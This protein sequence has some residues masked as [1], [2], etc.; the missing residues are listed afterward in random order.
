MPTAKRNCTFLT[1]APLVQMDRHAAIAVEYTHPDS[2]PYLRHS[3]SKR[4]A[5]PADHPPIPWGA[6]TTWAGLALPLVNSHS[7]TASTAAS[8]LPWERMASA[9]QRATLLRSSADRGA[10]DL[11]NFCCLSSQWPASSLFSASARGRIDGATGV[12]LKKHLQPRTGD[13]TH[14][15][16][17][18]IRARGRGRRGFW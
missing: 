18:M 7:S 14:A 13:R 17:S 6:P 1:S 5:P 4:P 11:K 10:D 16:A 15:I 3:S 8:A 2:T 9:S 12:P